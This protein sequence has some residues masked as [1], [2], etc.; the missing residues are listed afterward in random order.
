MTPQRFRQIREAKGLSQYE[1]SNKWDMS[2]RTVQR[3]E[4]GESKIPIPIAEI[5][6]RYAVDLDITPI[7]PLPP[8]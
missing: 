5:M 1:L 2:I 8:L 7:P 6:E 3:Y 4:S